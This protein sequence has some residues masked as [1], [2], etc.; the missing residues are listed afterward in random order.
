MKVGLMEHR[1]SWK[2]VWSKTGYQK[3]CLIQSLFLMVSPKSICCTS[4]P[5][6][7]AIFTHR[8]FL[9]PSR[10]PHIP[11]SVFVNWYPFFFPNVLHLPT[12]PMVPVLPKRELIDINFTNTLGFSYIL[13]KNLKPRQTY[14]LQNT[15]FHHP[16]SGTPTYSIAL[17]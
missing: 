15:L 14:Q 10:F 6:P 3:W 16:S 5:P 1:L 17:P 11:D 9:W 8:T 4:S 7:A 12:L 13:T 2:L